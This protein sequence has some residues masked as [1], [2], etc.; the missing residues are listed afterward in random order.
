[1][2]QW[3]PPAQQRKTIKNNKDDFPRLQKYLEK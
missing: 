3:I 1:M 2:P